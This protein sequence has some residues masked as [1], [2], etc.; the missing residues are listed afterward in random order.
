MSKPRRAH[1]A[2]RCTVRNPGPHGARCRY[3]AGHDPVDDGVNGHAPELDDVTKAD[4]S[5]VDFAPVGPIE[6]RAALREERA[7]RLKAQAERDG[8]AAEVA[9]L[10]A[11]RDSLERERD[12][13]REQVRSLTEQLA[14]AQAEWREER[15]DVRTLRE[16]VRSLTVERD[17]ARLP[18]AERADLWGM[19]ADRD[20][21]LSRAREALGSF[22]EN[23]P[24]YR[25]GHLVEGE[26]RIHQARALA[27]LRA[28]LAEPPASA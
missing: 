4:G 19:I 7:A 27:D 3:Q 12:E 23:P 22:D 1:G 26:W 16:S 5:P 24:P 9:L 15:G 6:L 10:F 28:A 11:E 2:E 18:E 20:R 13:A 25:A 17:A 14:A 8:W 21:R